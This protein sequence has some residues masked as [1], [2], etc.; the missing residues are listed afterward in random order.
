MI[1]VLQKN[2]LL[3]RDPV[4][5]LHQNVVILVKFIDLPSDLGKL[6]RIE[7]RNSGF[8]GSEGFTRKPRLFQRIK[9]HMIRHHNLNTIRNHELR[10]RHSL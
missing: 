10:R 4:D 1:E 3:I 6:I 9:L 2:I 7:R 8:G 5:L